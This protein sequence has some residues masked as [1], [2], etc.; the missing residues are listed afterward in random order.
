[1]PARMAKLFDVL[2]AGDYSS[3]FVKAVTCLLSAVVQRT[4]K[5]FLILVTH[6]V[7]TCNL[8][9]NYEVFSD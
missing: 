8:T 1:M 3:M 6:K 9:C 7:N 4:Y 5:P 2:A